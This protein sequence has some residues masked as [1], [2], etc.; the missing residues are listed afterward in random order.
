MRVMIE[1]NTTP[2]PDFRFQPRCHQIYRSKLHQPGVI[3]G[4]KMKLYLMETDIGQLMLGK[5]LG[6]IVPTIRHQARFLAM[7]VTGIRASDAA[8]RNK[9]SGQAGRLFSNLS[10]HTASCFARS[11]P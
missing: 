11:R 10:R 1:V 8:S 7:M 6:V 2:L 9:K 3:G 4:P 5:L